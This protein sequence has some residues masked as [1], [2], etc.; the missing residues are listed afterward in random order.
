MS[1]KWEK[2]ENNQ[3]VLTIEVEKEEVSSALDKAFKKVVKKVM[4]LAFE[5]QSTPSNF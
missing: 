4:S 2:L 3:G 5:R 1:A